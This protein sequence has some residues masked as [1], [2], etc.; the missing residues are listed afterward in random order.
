MNQGGIVEGTPVI[1]ALSRSLKY[2]SDHF[3]LVLPDL[4][5]VGSFRPA[6]MNFTLPRILIMVRPA[7]PLPRRYA[8]ARTLPLFEPRRLLWRLLPAAQRGVP[9]QL[10]DG[11]GDLGD[12]QRVELLD[13]LLH[14]LARLADQLRFGGLD[15]GHPLDLARLDLRHLLRPGL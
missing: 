9:L 11:V 13:D 15:G 4:S 12:V 2:L 8:T 14:L 10:G 1:S 3:S 5:L 7:I 6:A